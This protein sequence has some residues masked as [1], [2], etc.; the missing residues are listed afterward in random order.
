M[1]QID[2][3]ILQLQADVRDYNQKI[4]GATS[5][6]EQRL[7]RIEASG[8]KMGT[9]LRKGFDLAKT[10]AVG[11]VGVLGVEAVLGAARASLEYASSLG[12]LAQQL[13]VGT[14]FLQEFRYAASQ[15]GASVAAADQ[16]LAKYAVTLGK[17]FRGNGDAA[18]AFTSLGI[19]LQQL[20]AAS[21]SERFELIADAIRKIGEPT[22]QAAAAYEIFGR[23]AKELLPV[24]IGGAGGFRKLAIE[25]RE[26]GL[27][28]SQDQIENA[29]K[30]ADKLASLQNVLKVRVASAIL[31]N[32]SA[33]DQLVNSLARLIPA[34]FRAVQ[35][36]ANFDAGVRRYNTDATVGE[37]LDLL[38]SVAR[39]DVVG[40]ARNAGD[41][42][43]RG[44][45][46]APAKPTAKDA[47][48]KDRPDAPKIDFPITP[49][50][51]GGGGGGGGAGQSAA[52]RNR[53]AA[54]DLAEVQRRFTDDLTRVQQEL[55]RVMADLSGTIE[56]RAKAELAAI[57]SERAASEKDAKLRFGAEDV[58]R[59]QL[60][61]ANNELAEKQKQVVTERLASEQR[62]RA[63]DIVDLALDTEEESLRG[64][65]DLART[66]KQ[67]LDLETS[68]V[69][70]AFERRK[71]A[72][73]LQIA[74]EKDLERKKAL[75]AQLDALPQQQART[76]AGVDERNAGPLKRYLKEFEDPETLVEQAVV[77]KMRAINATITKSIT[78][79]LGID[80]PFLSRLIEIF[81]QQNI[82]KPL[83]DAFSNAG[84]GGGGF[85][86]TLFGAA[87]NLFGGGGSG[88]LG[89]PPTGP[90][91][92]INNRASGG[93]VGPR[94]TVRV[95]E[96][97]GG[98]ELLRMGSQGGTVI[99]LGQVNQSVTRA[100]P[101]AN[102]VATV[103]L[104][105]SD[106]I[107]A[108][109]VKTSGPVAVEVLRAGAPGI[110]E[111]ATQNTFAQAERMRI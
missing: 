43:A 103:Q 77:D 37:R 25:A 41:V 96:Q 65:L 52:E 92:N 14:N 19:S 49:L 17:A 80:D 21:D 36:L 109:I 81:L 98:A 84:G 29:D 28:L 95:N 40:A 57:E 1:P 70:I 73:A 6:T 4:A 42:L 30:I 32:A 76:Q 56:E 69:A 9:N 100:A 44:Q 94:Q 82:F 2:P 3:V 45:P 106:D 67:R 60:I 39:G 62:R 38:A 66:A 105:L 88:G 83:A 23:G 15:N 97:S 46:K 7:A 89:R 18:Q 85:F 22:R 47:R 91:K 87:T 74:D 101:A 27:V 110:V 50:R 20:N 72:L 51:G 64:Q 58:R 54:A 79:T 78:D 26:L 93:Y 31:D 90:I 16:A 5:M 86:E 107:D 63:A 12:E 59:Q 10:A 102:G 34:A 104:M 35:A 55:L 48:A 53:A 33:I 99:P 71:L 8:F 61:A 68:L 24:L 75:Q 111:A 108:R 13:S 11:F